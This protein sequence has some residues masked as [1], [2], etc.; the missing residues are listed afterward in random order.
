MANLP[1]VIFQFAL[2]PYKNWQ[3]LAWSGALLVT[4]TILVLSIS[5]RIAVSASGGGAKR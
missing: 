3:Q 4:V 2:S 5:A 1:V